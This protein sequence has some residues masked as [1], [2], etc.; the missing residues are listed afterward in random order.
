[1]K[2]RVLRM[3][4]NHLLEIAK[5][6]GTVQGGHMSKVQEEASEKTGGRSMSIFWVLLP[7]LS[8]KNIKPGSKDTLIAHT[9]VSLA[10]GSL[11]EW[12][13]PSLNSFFNP[14]GAVSRE[15]HILDSRELPY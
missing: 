4:W 1:M 14:K 8:G 6:L 13:R 3:E 7:Y 2:D 5:M 10:K 12:P 11:R 9:W 15:L